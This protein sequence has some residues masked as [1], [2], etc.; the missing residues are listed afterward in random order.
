M[1][2]LQVLLVLQCHLLILGSDLCHYLGQVLAL[3]SVHIHLH[4]GLGDLGTELHHILKK[5]EPSTDLS[6][7]LRMASQGWYHSAQ[8][9]IERYLDWHAL[10]A[11]TLEV[12]FLSLSVTL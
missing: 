10:H 8:L 12:C 4:S 3:R 7:L 1:P 6:D 11:V 2:C 5:P 9:E